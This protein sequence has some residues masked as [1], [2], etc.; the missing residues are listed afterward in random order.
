MFYVSERERERERNINNV[1]L[2]FLE[3][4]KIQQLVTE[5]NWSQIV[6]GMEIGE[7]TNIELTFQ[8][9]K[10][11]AIKFPKCWL[12]EKNFPMIF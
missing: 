2:S 5:L 3:N 10:T 4:W 9:D 11:D 12:K 7:C 1:Y 8:Q 6:N